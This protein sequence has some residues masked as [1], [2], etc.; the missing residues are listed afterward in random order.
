MKK[1]LGLGV[2]LLSVIPASAGVLENRLAE[3]VRSSDNAA[4]KS[5]LASHAN[6]NA[7]LPDKSTVLS[8]AID[9]QDAQLVQMLLGAGA[10]VNVADSEGTTPLSLACELG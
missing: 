8:W 1:A 2:V 3:A 9:R 10:K 6:V 4:V 7:P 5:L